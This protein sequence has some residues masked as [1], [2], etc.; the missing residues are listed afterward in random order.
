ME[1]DYKKLSKFMTKKQSR[2]PSKLQTDRNLTWRAKN[3]KD[4]AGLPQKKYSTGLLSVETGLI[5]DLVT[6]KE[7]GKINAELLKASN[8]PPDLW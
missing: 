2:L 1:D 4:L 5:Y 7:L 8:F 6:I 3:T